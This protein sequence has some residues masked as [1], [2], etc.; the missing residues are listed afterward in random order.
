MKKF[1]YLA[2]QSPRRWQLLEQL[3][4]A[5]ELLLPAEDED[6][7]ALEAML[8]NEAPMRYVQR[9][10]QLKLDAAL[11]RLQD[12]KLPLAPVLC[13]DT[14]VA[15]GRSILG[16]PLDTEDAERILAVLSGKTHRVL[17]AIALGTLQARQQALLGACL[18]GQAFANSPVAA[19]HALAYPL[20]TRF[21]LPHGL[22]NALMLP[23]VMRFNLPAAA[24]QY[25][26]LLPCAFP[27]SQAQGDAQSR[28]EQ[29]IVLLEGLIERVGLPKRLR[30]VGIMEEH[31]DM[32]ATDAM[33]QTR[34]LVNNPRPVTEA[35]ALAIY[36]A[37]Y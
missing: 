11:Q 25:A 36:T 29:F 37:A 19:V 12:R 14:T 21:H 15:L 6:A 24:E 20:G 18:A 4:V 10:T 9:V 22:T 1:V 5:Y 17:T 7:E 32:L 13:S 27:E 2:S 16:K 26:Q 8:P 31:I 35:D 34:L 28:A 33:K 3:G 23:T 30:E